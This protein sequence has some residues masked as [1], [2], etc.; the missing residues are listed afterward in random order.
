MMNNKLISIILV[1][2]LATQFVV[3]FSMFPQTTFENNNNTINT[4]TIS[5]FII[6][7]TDLDEVEWKS[8]SF[9]NSKFE[10]WSQDHRPD[11]LSNDRTLEAY[12][13]YASSPWPVNQGSRSLGLQVRAMDPDH[14]ATKK[15]NQQS[16][17]SWLNPSNTTLSFDWYIDELTSPDDSDY[18]NVEI[19]MGN[20]YLHY[21]LGS[22]RTLTNNSLYAYF[23]I[24]GPSDT[25]NVLSRNLTSDYYGAFGQMPTQYRTMYFNLLTYSFEYSRV[26][27]DDLWLMNGTDVKIGGSFNHGDFELGGT[28]TYWWYY[29]NTD[30]GDISKSTTR[31]EGDYSINTTVLSSGNK[32]YASFGSSVNKR[33]SVL[34]KGQL[35]FNWQ[36]EEWINPEVLTYSYVEIQCENASEGWSI[37]Y[38]FCTDDLEALGLGYLGDV[39][40]LADDFNTTG[41]WNSFN[42]TIWDDMNANRTEDDFF[43]SQIEFY[44]SATNPGSRLTVLV[45]DVSFISANLNLMSFEDQLDAGEP[46]LGFGYDYQPSDYFKV[47]DFAHTGNKAGNL[48]LTDGNDD[49]IEQKLGAIPLNSN[50][51]MILDFNWYLEDFNETSDDLLA[52]NIYFDDNTI[53]Y[54]LANGSGGD[55]SE[56]IDDDFIILTEVNSKGSWHNLK[57]SL[58]IDFQELFGA[59]PNTTITSFELISYVDSDSSLTVFLDD[60]YLYE[61]EFAPEISNI[62]QS[63]AIPEVGDA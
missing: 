12:A 18:F 36:V 57:R 34:N 32:S 62:T 54:I 58:F 49:D 29:S 13:W 28:G 50:K 48:T 14:P 24:D 8:N 11:D 30:P 55:V 16:Q 42:Q 22:T 9:P 33:V 23:M 40:L 20:K 26:F 61:E 53:A 21:Y 17:S 19:R 1:T 4:N 44:T 37:Y 27:V 25:W 45:D 46:V 6:A 38:V 51:E 3:L 56:W 7:E 31:I 43:V 60:M 63:I 2:L 15:F 41:Q 35:S 47:T 59:A 5:D 39:I 52:V 10:D